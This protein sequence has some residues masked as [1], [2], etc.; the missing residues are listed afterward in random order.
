MEINNESQIPIFMQVADALRDAI[1][2]GAFGE[3]T[4]I[5]STTEISI[6]YRI[7]PATVL[8][9]MNLLVEEQLIAKRR[10]V[11]MFVSIGARERIKEMRY[12]EFSKNY[13]KPLV[14]EA[15]KLELTDEQIAALIKKEMKTDDT[16]SE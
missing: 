11:G 3:D 6:A 8:K 9:G 16:K 14:L 15:R 13:I 7:N 4:Q 12:S 1:F 10:G 5:P 2:T